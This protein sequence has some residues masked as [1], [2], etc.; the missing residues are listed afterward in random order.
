MKER[1][2]KIYR[3]ADNNVYL[4]AVLYLVLHTGIFFLISNFREPVIYIHTSIDDII[5]VCE[6]FIIPYVMWF[7]AFAGA[8]IFFAKNDRKNYWRLFIAL[9]L[10]TVLCSLIYLI[11]PNA[12]SMEQITRNENIF[13]GLL[14][15]VWYVDNPTNACPSLHVLTS[16][17]IA[18]V[19]YYSDYFRDKALSKWLIIVFMILIC[20]ST[21]FV[22]QH[23]I[24]DVLV[25]GILGIVLSLISKRVVK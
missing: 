17:V 21:M 3:W 9:F 2:K 6:Y 20:I 16:T 5:P 22:K 8:L 15:L 19:V 23:S 1:L 13:S 12:I 14:N 25:G 11:V 24:I 7:L 4:C 18:V 10:G